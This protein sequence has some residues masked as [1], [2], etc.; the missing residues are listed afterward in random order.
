MAVG[1]AEGISRKRWELKKRLGS[2]GGS[3]SRGVPAGQEPGESFHLEEQLSHGRR[4]SSKP[5]LSSLKNVTYKLK[6]IW[7][8][9][10]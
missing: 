4:C 2:W 5:G 8:W 9:L 1:C 6:K 10:F 3:R 7:Q